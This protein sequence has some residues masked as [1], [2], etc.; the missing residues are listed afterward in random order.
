[1]S[2]LEMKN[3]LKNQP[4]PTYSKGEELFNWISHI[5]GMAFGLV[6]LGLAIAASIIG[7]F[8]LI[9]CIS[10]IFYAITIIVLYGNSTIYHAL[11]KDSTWKRLFRLIDHNTIYLLIAGTYAPICAFAFSTSNIGLIIFL[12]QIVGLLIGTILNVCNLNGK[13]TKVVTVIL[14]VVMGWAIM[15]YWPAMTMLPIASMILILLGGISYTAGVGFYA[16]GK[17]KKWMHSIFHLFVLI[18][19]IL[20]FIGIVFIII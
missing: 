17:K 10:L 19:T 2:I 14:Y 3:T 15:F 8:T 1:M 20:Q 18:G 6:V 4:I 12:V 7:Q 9:Q 11:P 16:A 5:I 13:I